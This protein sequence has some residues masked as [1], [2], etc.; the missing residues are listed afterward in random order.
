MT[1]IQFRV[2]DL[3]A[4]LAGCG[5]MEPTP[6]GRSL[7][8]HR[9]IDSTND[10]ARTLAA[11]GEPEGTVILADEQTR[12]R[13]RAERTWHSPPGLGLYMSIILRPEA[14]A[15]RAPLL[16]LMA[17][18]A[19]AV[20]LGA[21]IKWP[22]DLLIGGRKVAGILTEAR[23]AESRIRDVVVGM[24]ININQRLS[25]FPPEIARTATSL[26]LVR[27]RPLERVPV[28]LD[29]LTAFAR[30][31][32][33]WLSAGDARVLEEFQTLAVDLNGRHVRV[34]EGAS[35]WTGKTAGI[36]PEGALRVR[37]DDG[38]DLAEVRYGEVTRVMEI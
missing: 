7:E 19:G 3:R 11:S 35:A 28:A 5:I 24:G 6:I 4:H 8:F 2:E 30:W 26:R 9:R 16:G 38:G 33:L 10:R 13:G 29:I 32:K 17:A 36:S 21:D 18:V 31:Y 27:G 1:R 25:D 34:I 20:A 23:S 22:N 14:P 15:S 37:R 12:G